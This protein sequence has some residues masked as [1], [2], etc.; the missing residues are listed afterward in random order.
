MAS[1]LFA[2]AALALAAEP[3]TGAAPLPAGKHVYRATGDDWTLTVK[4]AGVTYVSRLGR[5]RE[6]WHSL[7]AAAKAIPGGLRISGE[8]WKSEV[9]AN[10]AVDET[11]DFEATLL[12]RPCR[13]GRGRLRPVTILLSTAWRDQ[14][15]DVERGCGRTRPA[16][17]GVP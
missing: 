7:H 11:M 6:R 5:Y 17:A 13:T 1:I 2:A 8:L 9:V 12:D 16:P 3:P 4:P 10:E 15:P 14:P